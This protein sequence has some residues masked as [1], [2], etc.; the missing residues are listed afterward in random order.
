M[1]DEQCTHDTVSGCESGSQLLDRYEERVVEW[2]RCRV[3][4]ERKATPRPIAH[5]D[6]CHHAQRL[7]RYVRKDLPL[8]G[9]D[10]AL[11]RS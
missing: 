7:P 3:R 5:G 2:L 10:K 4:L 8:R 9:R 11:V 6:L 1:T